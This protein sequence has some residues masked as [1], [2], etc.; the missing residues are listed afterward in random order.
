MS[1]AEV[2]ASSR[3]CLA[4]FD[5]SLMPFSASAKSFFSSE[6][7]CSDQ[8]PWFARAWVVSSMESSLKT[9]SLGTTNAALKAARGRM[10]ENLMFA[11]GIESFQ[12]AEVWL[13]I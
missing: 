12:T 8:A 6:R 2:K 11:D 1:E 9:C 3:A 4:L 10:C 13:P 5:A 7:T